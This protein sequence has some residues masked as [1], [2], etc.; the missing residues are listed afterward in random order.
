MSQMQ[1]TMESPAIYRVRVR[2]HLPLDW[3][4]MLQG[5]NITASD[6]GPDHLSTLVGRLPNQSALAEL[7]SALYERQYPIVSVEC[8]ELG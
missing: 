8:L 4:E 1:A 6:T 2:G 7:L 3:S 5:M